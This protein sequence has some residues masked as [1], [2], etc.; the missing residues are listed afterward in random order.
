MSEEKQPPNFRFFY[1]FA[2]REGAAH[3]NPKRVICPVI[4]F[5]GEPSYNPP[6]QTLS[7]LDIMQLRA[8]IHKMIDTYFDTMEKENFKE[9][10]EKKELSAPVADLILPSKD[11]VEK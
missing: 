2:I 10:R 5:K 4:K 1:S 11:V 9:A 8:K 7:A 3:L 6:V